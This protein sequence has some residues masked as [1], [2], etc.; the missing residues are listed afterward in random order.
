MSKIKEISTTSN[1][2]VMYETI[3]KERKLIQ[4][5]YVGC[6]Q[7][8]FIIIR[9]PA[10]MAPRCDADPFSAGHVVKI[11]A[12]VNLNSQETITFSST[13]LRAVTSSERLLFLSYPEKVDSK[14]LR[15]EPRL[16]VELFAEIRFDDMQTEPMLC[17]IKDVSPS[18]IGCE[19]RMKNKYD[20]P[21][22]SE[23]LN[24]KCTLDVDMNV[25]GLNTIYTFNAVIK[26]IS[27]KEKIQL[28][29]FFDDENQEQLR[30]LFEKLA[31]ENVLY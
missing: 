21:N 1:I 24:K 29:L 17:L 23:L 27:K 12:V 15:A 6:S 30:M 11:S 10:S 8:D 14:V 25:Y 31:L 7:K 22:F 18:G 16:T 13:I 3:A 2:D 5:E 20:N 9:Y 4:C 19:F 26:N 28:G